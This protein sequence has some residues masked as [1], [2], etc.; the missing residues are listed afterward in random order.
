MDY[1]PVAVVLGI[2][3]LGCAAE[4]PAAQVSDMVPCAPNAEQQPTTLDGFITVHVM[5][6]NVQLE[7][8]PA[9]L[10]RSHSRLHRVLRFVDRC[11]GVCARLGGRQ[12][13]GAVGE[14]R[15][16]GRPADRAL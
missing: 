3:L 1:G 2:A 4:V 8:P 9:M 7:I 12:P 15:Q 16:Q 6:G 10:N 5:C 11:F 13:P 14:S